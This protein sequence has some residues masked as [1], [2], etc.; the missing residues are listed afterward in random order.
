LL[1]NFAS[2]KPSFYLAMFLA[3]IGTY[4]F[5]NGMLVWVIGL[6]VLL[7]SRKLAPPIKTKRILVWLGAAIIV[8]G[9]Y[10]YH[11]KKPEHHPP[12]LFLFKRPD[13]YL[14]YVSMFLGNPLGFGRFYHSATFGILGLV[15]LIFLVFFLIRVRRVDSNVLLPYIG[16]SLYSLM[17]AALTGVGRCGAGCGAALCPRYVTT[18]TPLW[19]S[20]TALLYLVIVTK[21]KQVPQTSNP[22]CLPIFCTILILTIFVLFSW[23][24]MDTVRLFK[25][26]NELFSKLRVLLYLGIDCPAMTYLYPSHDVIFQRREILRKYDLSVFH[27]P[28]PLPA[29]ERP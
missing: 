18:T 8:I 16:L 28:P 9:S 20:I 17:T 7:F 12:L 13:V 11:Y 19:I 26:H 14:E 21:P 10:L 6:G 15:L 3:L 24:S 4:S 29:P 22:R 27:N 2:K 25:A 23:N 5:A 1:S